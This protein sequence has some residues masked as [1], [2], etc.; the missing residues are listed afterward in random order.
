MTVVG[1]K[2]LRAPSRLA[3]ERKKHPLFIWGNFVLLATA[4]TILGLAGLALI[5]MFIALVF[6]ESAL[7]L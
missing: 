4:G 7:V 6:Q 3:D 1:G 5:Q 2:E